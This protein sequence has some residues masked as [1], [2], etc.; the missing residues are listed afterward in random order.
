MRFHRSILAV[1][2]STLLVAALAACSSGSDSSVSAGE[3]LVASKACGSCHTGSKGLLAG[4]DAAL[5]GVYA[6]NI[7]PHAS[8]GIGAWTDAQIKTAIK[9]GK[10]DEGEALCGSMT[11]FPDLTDAELTDIVAYLRSVPAIDNSVTE[12]SC[13]AP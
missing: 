13:A 12:G 1:L 4:G 6:P 3:T 5:S 2:S 7:T 10:D 9:E 8:T 11:R